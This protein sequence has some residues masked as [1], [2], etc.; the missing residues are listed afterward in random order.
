[1]QPNANTFEEIINA[2]VDLSQAMYATYMMR[3]FVSLGIHAQY[4]QRDG[5][6]SHIKIEAKDHHYL[7][8]RPIVTYDEG[9]RIEEPMMRWQNFP[10]EIKK[11]LPETHPGG[12]YYYKANFTLFIDEFDPENPEAEDS[13]PGEIASIDINC[14]DFQEFIFGA[15]YAF[16][17]HHNVEVFPKMRRSRVEL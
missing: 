8:I 12:F 17:E 7:E 14:S 4:I 9:I 11:I 3:R 13:G 10:N 5:A 1:M 6:F 16:V 15:L 2:N